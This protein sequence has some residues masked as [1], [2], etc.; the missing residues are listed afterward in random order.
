MRFVALPLIS[1][2]HKKNSTGTVQDSRLFS[3]GHVF[4]WNQGRTTIMYS[5]GL[6]DRLWFNSLQYN[7]SAKNKMICT[8]T[9]SHDQRSTLNICTIH[10][11]AIVYVPSGSRWWSGDLLRWLKKLI[12]QII[13][14]LYGWRIESNTKL[15]TML[16]SNTTSYILIHFGFKAS[17]TCRFW[18][19][20]IHDSMCKD[21]F[22]VIMLW[23]PCGNIW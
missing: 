14:D 17:W 4:S 15:S 12:F 23:C 6:L 16:T 20:R 22:G 3:I 8:Y 1:L 19:Y 9:S 7:I 11:M 21:P 2:L 13:Q 5:L 10:N 18:Q